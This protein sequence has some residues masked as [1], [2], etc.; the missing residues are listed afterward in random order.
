MT[1]LKQLLSRFL[2]AIVFTSLAIYISSAQAQDIVQIDDAWAGESHAGQAVGAAYM[3]FLSKQDIVL[4]QIES[5]VAKTVEIHNMSM[6]NNIMK[7][8]MLESLPI[9][10]AKITKLAPGGLHLMLFDL[11]NPLLQGDAI[12]LTLTFSTKN[13]TSF[14]QAIKVPVKRIHSEH[15]DH[16]HHHH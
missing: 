4:M 15:D 13:G 3:R 12:Q 10:A 5:D 16:S 6:E 7:M 9:K 11:K 14:K 8:R 2:S 1:T